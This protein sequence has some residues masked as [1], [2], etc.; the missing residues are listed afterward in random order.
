MNL[1]TLYGLK[2][3]ARL[4]KIIYEIAVEFSQRHTCTLISTLMKTSFARTYLH[5]LLLLGISFLA[6][7]KAQAT[8]IVGAELYYSC[9]D[10]T[11]STYRLTLK[12]YRDCFLGQAPFDNPIYLFVFDGNTGTRLQ[13]ISIPIPA[14]TPQIVP[15]NWDSCVATPYTICVQEGVY[16]TTAVLP[17]RVGGY[18][19]AWARCCRNSA[20]TNLSNPL[21]EGA[22]F[23]AHIPDSALARCNSMP[24]FKQVPPIF[25]C[26]NQQFNFDHSALD[27]DGDSLVYALVDPYTGVDLLNNGAANNLQNPANP[28]PV[29]NVTNPMGPPPYRTVGFQTGYS[30]PDPFGSGNF[31]INS[32]TGFLSVTPNQ[33]GIFV[34]AISVF[35]YRNGVLLSENRRDFQIHVLNCLPQGKPPVIT[36]DLSAL[37][38]SNDTVFVKADELF[39]FPVTVTDVNPV[40]VLTAYTVSAAFG[41]GTFTPPFA[42]F[43][44]SGTNP[45]T[46]T[47]CWKPACQYV[48]QTIPLI[49]GAR[50]TGD[51][52]NIGDVFDTVYVN[53]SLD[54][55]QGPTIIPDLSGLTTSGDTIIIQAKNSFCFDFEV[56]D[57]NLKDSLITFPSSPIFND[58]NG[59]S[60]TWSGKNPLQGKI[61]WQPSCVY[62]GQVIPLTIG[63]ADYATCNRSLSASRT[64]YVKI[65]IP[66]NAP[67]RIVPNLSGLQVQGDTICVTATDSFCFTFAVL[68]ANGG[69]TLTAMGVSPIFS[70]PGG[71]TITTNG[72]N[73]VTGTVC[74]RPG[75]Q[76]GGQVIPLV[77]AAQD[78][79]QCTNVGHAWDTLFVKIIIPPNAPPTANHDFTGIPRT[80][81]DTIFVDANE[82]FCYRINFD[83]INVNDSL[84]V[85]ALSTVFSTASPPATISLIG[86]NPVIATVCWQP[87]CSFEGQTI[88]FVVE[89]KDNGICNTQLSTADTV[90][91]KISDPVTL[92][93]IVITDL[94]GTAHQGDTIFVEL[95]D[96]VCYDFMVVDRT[97][98]NGLNATYRF[99]DLA[100]NNLGLGYYQLTHRKDT[101]F[102]RVC[103]RP[104][105]TNG[106][107]LY[108]TVITGIDGATCP[109]FDIAEAFVFIKV[110]TKFLSFAGVDVSYCEGTGG[111]T[112]N[113]GPIGGKGPYAY[114]WTCDDPGNCGLGNRNAPN[115]LVNPNKSSTYYVQITDA[116]GCT[117]ELDSVVVTINAKPIVDAGRDVFLCQGQPGVLLN[118]TVLNSNKA[119]GP[120][121]YQWSPADG[122]SDAKAQRPYANPANTTIYTLMVTSANGCNSFTTTLDSLSTVV[123]NRVSTPIVD[124]GPDVDICFGDSVPMLGFAT[125][126]HPPFQY[127]W[128]PAQ[129]MTQPQSPFTKAAPEFTTTYS[130]VVWSHGCPS[131]ADSI[132]VRVH[133]LPTAEP[134]P[135]WEICQGDSIQLPGIAGG[136]LLVDYTYDWMPRHG[137]SD[138]F[139]PQPYAFPDTTT[140]YT[141]VATSIHGCGSVPYETKVIVAPTPI[142]DAGPDGYVCMGDSIQLDGSYSF[143]GAQPNGGTVFFTWAPAPGLKERFIA[144]PMVTPPQTT[145]YVLRT[146]YRACATEDEVEIAVFNSPNNTLITAD[147]NVI[148]QGDSVQLHA[149]AGLGSATYTW[150]PPASLS[151][152]R[153]A[154]PWA[155]PMQDQVYTVFIDEGKCSAMDSIA[156]RVK[157]TPSA[158]FFHSQATGCAPLEV[159][160]HSVATQALAYTWDFGDGTSTSNI[161]DPVHIFTEPGDYQ[162]RFKTTGEG[163]C[164]VHNDSSWITILPAVEALF[165]SDPPRSERFVLPDV[166]IQFTDLS[167]HAVSWQWDFGDGGSAIEQH[168]THIF[169]K[170]GSFQVT[171]TVTGEGGCRDT[172]SLGPYQILLPNL[173]LP[174]VFTP[175]EDGINDVFGIEYSGKEPFTLQVFDRWGKLAHTSTDPSIPW[176]G[177]RINGLAAAEGVYYYVLQVGENSF[178]GNVTLMR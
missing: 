72:I 92:P 159:A 3:Q 143:R 131:K 165:S 82:A 78:Q 34:L 157:P 22:T 47:I 37:P 158:E 59:P 111:I 166:P 79:G 100:G 106:G 44:W 27:L 151:D 4:G 178:T 58:P 98:G 67:P 123:V 141:L 11:T 84:T 9:L 117:S 134:G 43:N 115:P 28:P 53:I 155:F 64:L 101:I 175:N 46:G 154:A 88:M 77:L 142:A 13:I 29:V 150:E 35:E 86:T 163:G 62:A 26:A 93:P 52:P 30:F 138:P 119:P 171:L 40:D 124:A 73:P 6:V 31:V 45:I 20:I 148:C 137:L 116:N 63:A 74:W 2:I 103:F 172:F 121:T 120:Y 24:V 127:Q 71:P 110:N 162:I 144:D 96:S 130:L 99:E 91:V 5:F 57:P 76:Y 33:T 66:P 55:N 23:L 38:H 25:L 139:A 125:G 70:T 104:G 49:I 16:E 19:L 146:N 81:G 10:T 83:D 168:P 50:D 164:E 51:C 41:N 149:F 60:F 97:F 39:C 7:P 169:R 128:S 12:M 107:G 156:I 129:G 173:Y 15:A 69:D 118:P 94:S 90:W 42:T 48:N 8:H 68:D 161:P 136:D 108:R 95:G 32:Q 54:P 109:P 133:A 80:I 18:D 114:V 126:S 132:T 105:C 14:N 167:S 75:C 89:A 160:F 36:H 140:T 65:N 56:T 112:L 1:Y 145:R 113:G 85:T 152:P 61:C 87:D 17:P 170:P 176:N 153:A 135:A 177:I 102:G 21:G 174:N 147:T 122:L